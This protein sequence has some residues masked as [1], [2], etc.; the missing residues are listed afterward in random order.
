M[1]QKHYTA[2]TAGFPMYCSNVKRFTGSDHRCIALA[3]Y[4][5]CLTKSLN[6]AF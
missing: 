3:S 5:N 6:C 4:I 1:Q 2:H